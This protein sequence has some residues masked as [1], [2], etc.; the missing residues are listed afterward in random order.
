MTGKKSVGWFAGLCAA[1]LWMP[2]VSL[3]ATSHPAPAIRTVA[4]QPLARRIVPLMD[5]LAQAPGWRAAL[6]RD[7]DMQALAAERMA[8]IN[9]AGDCVPQPACLAQAWMWSEADRDRVSGALRRIGADRARLT[10]LVGGRMRPSRQY[11]RHADLADAALLEA[12]WREAAAGL[13][14][15][16]AVYA[17][18]E[19]PRYPVIDSMIFDP[20]DPSYPALLKSHAA[21]TLAEG[22]GDDTV[23]DPA[24][25]YAL[26]LLAA[27]ERAN[28]AEY[29]PLSSGL[30]A[31]AFAALRA[32]K[33]N[34]YPYS[35]VLVFG[36]GPEDPVSHTGVLGHL[37][38]RLAAAQL[39]K[40]AAPVIILSGGRVHP[41][42]TAYNEAVEMRHELISLYGVSPA[43]IVIEPHAR[44]T[45]TNLRNCARLLLAA[46]FAQ[47]KP[48]L[49]VTDPAT[50]AY[51][52]SEG[53][54][55]RNR[56]ELG[57]EPGRVT[58]GPDGLS[59]RFVPDGRSFHVDP[60]DPLDP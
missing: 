44:H 40:G 11:A 12:A 58:A 29:L 52:A 8:R 33:Q 43:Q 50:H 1:L 45:T 31:P 47:G 49:L 42:R 55:A 5:D 25:R 16:V 37:R 46:P 35:A 9:A 53:F 39:A 10:A 26:G 36:H 32:M 21:V 3:A 48:A 41:N 19:K 24:L 23:F 22:R 34:A 30:N 6:R 15:I 59:L 2:H 60:Q 20:R 14:H 17:L 51:I 7:A 56:A 54:A 27:N 13:N 4:D 38:L 57:Y 18:G 28:A